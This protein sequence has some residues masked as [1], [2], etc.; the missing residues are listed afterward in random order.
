MVVFVVVVVMM[1]VHEGFNLNVGSHVLESRLH[2]V[3]FGRRNPCV[4]GEG[5]TGD[6]ELSGRRV[7]LIFF[8]QVLVDSE[9]VAAVVSS[10]TLRIF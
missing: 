10:P 6:G 3:G 7:N 2:G 1:V 9:D 5:L 8:G 4:Q